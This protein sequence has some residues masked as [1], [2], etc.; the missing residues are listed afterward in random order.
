MV[1]TSPSDPQTVPAASS[2]RAESYGWLFCILVAL[3][4][5]SFFSMPHGIWAPVGRGRALTWQAD[6]LCSLN[7]VLPRQSPVSGCGLSSSLALAILSVVSFVVQKLFSQPSVL[8]GE[9]AY[10]EGWGQYTPG[11]G[12]FR[13]FLRRHVGPEPWPRYGTF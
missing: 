5:P 7:P 1:L 10:K 13:A 8:Q 6:L 9:P 11:G 3:L 12:E 2:L 4:N